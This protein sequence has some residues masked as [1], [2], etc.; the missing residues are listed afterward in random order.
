MSKLS[1]LLQHILG[2]QN[3]FASGGL[4]LMIIGAISVH[5]RA[6]P[7][8]LWFWIVEQTTMTIT[9]K[10]DDAAFAW[11]K[12]WFLEQKFLERIRHVDLD[13]TLRGQGTALI[14]AP[15]RHRFWH[16]GRPFWV[17]FTRSE[18]TK[19]WTPRRIESL[20]FR[21]IGRKQ[22]FLKRFVGEIVACHQRKVKTASYLYVYDEVWTWV[23]AYTPRLLDSVILKPGERERL[24]DDIEKFPCIARALPISGRAISSGL[25][26]VRAS[27]DRQDFSGVGLGCAVRHVG[28]CGELDRVQ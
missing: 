15:G 13:T 23:Q 10:D 22:I 11:I 1:D 24:V 4:L 9:V 26:V 25:L 19:G 3:Q 2:G 21:T 7:T 17:W 5:L 6:L 14:P 18:D 28:L 27:R 20:T 16:G 12:E 8:N